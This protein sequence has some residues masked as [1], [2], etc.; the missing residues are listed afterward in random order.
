MPKAPHAPPRLADA[1][2]ARAVLLE[3]SDYARLRTVEASNPCD[4]IDDIVVALQ[5]SPDTPPP[6]GLVPYLQRMSGCLEVAQAMRVPQPG[7]VEQPTTQAPPPAPTPPSVGVPQPRKPTT[8]AP[9]PAPTPPSPPPSAASVDRAVP[10]ATA[11]AIPHAHRILNQ[12]DLTIPRAAA[13]PVRAAQTTPPTTSTSQAPDRARLQRLSRQAREAIDRAVEIDEQ[14]LQPRNSIKEGRN[15]ATEIYAWFPSGSVAGAHVSVDGDTLT[16]SDVDVCSPSRSD[17][18]DVLAEVLERGRQTPGPQLDSIT[19]EDL[20]PTVREMLNERGLR[21]VSYAPLTFA[22][23]PTTS[24]GE[25]TQ[26][27]LDG[28][29]LRVTVPQRRRAPPRTSYHP[30][31][32][33]RRAL[34]DARI[35]AWAW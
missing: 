15:R 33:S 29:T 32:R 1:V 4:S 24:L 18:G 3:A 5:S 12:D 26:E 6:P 31:A 8:Q 17:L 30:T 14:V 2:L 20:V 27:R 19:A 25:I 35:P 22:L 7:G 11:S 28:R 23:P 10:A 21:R 9:S 13:M 34:H 16:V